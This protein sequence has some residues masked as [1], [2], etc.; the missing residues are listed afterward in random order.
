MNAPPNAQTDPSQWPKRPIVLLGDKDGNPPT[1]ADEVDFLIVREIQLDAG[2]RKVDHATFDYDLAGRGERLVDMQTPEGWSRVVEVRLPSED[3]SGEDTVLFWG[4]LTK[5]SLEIDDGEK[6]AITARV[7]PY[8][9]GDPAEGQVVRRPGNTLTATI[10]Q[11]LVFNPEIDGKLVNNRGSLKHPDHDYY[12]WL[13]P[14]SSR[15]Q[16]AK[17]YQEA[18]AFEWLLPHVIAALMWVCNPSEEFVDNLDV[19]D[20]LNDDIFA[21]AQPVKNLKL[22]AGLRLPQYLDRL[23]PP[24]GYDWTVDVSLDQNGN[25]VRR[26][27]ILKQGAGNKKQVYFQSPGEELDLTQ[28]NT[29]RP[30]VDTDVGDITNEVLGLGALEERELTIELVRC[31]PEDKD[32]LAAEDLHKETGTEFKSNRNVWRKWAANLGGDYCGTRTDVAPIGDEPPDLT[33]YFTELV[34]KRRKAEP[35]LTRDASNERRRVFVEW[36]DPDADDGAGGG[37]KGKWRPAEGTFH[38][39]LLEHEVGIYFDGNEIPAEIYAAGDD[40]KIRITCTI[41]GDA[42]L[43]ATSFKEEDSPSGRTIKIQLDLGDRFFDRKV[44][45]TGEHQSVLKD[46]PYSADEKDDQDAL[47]QYVDRLRK[48]ADGARME[49]EIPLFGIQLGYQIGDVITAIEGRNLN[50]S[51]KSPQSATKLYP[52]VAGLRWSFQ[53]P[54]MTSLTLQFAEERIALE[55]IV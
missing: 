38:W 43:S 51:R 1:A 53:A 10:H 7:E 2:G 9:F 33:P 34:P 29:P 8:H 26:L 46:E 6:A 37:G 23:L 27:R 18:E 47:Q 22:P 35:C 19:G 50:L 54:Q 20:L 15:T 39:D 32:G 49:I 21:E 30:R 28:S 31:W 11:D 42:R 4:E 41:V 45:T 13:D 5:Q 44:Q 25:C 3:P 17:D 16:T 12:V 48:I 24:F 14:E 55:K 36:W 40:A 52:H